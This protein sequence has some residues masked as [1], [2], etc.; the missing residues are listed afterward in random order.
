M[1]RSFNIYQSYISESLIT[2]KYSKME[3]KDKLTP[4]KIKSLRRSLPFGG[5]VLIHKITGKS[6]IH[7]KSAL[8]GKYYAQQVYDIAQDIIEWHRKH[9]TIEN[10]PIPES[11]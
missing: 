10:Y 3:L 7:V 2:D 8:G 9:K 1:S 5:G 11:K 4:R 6:Y